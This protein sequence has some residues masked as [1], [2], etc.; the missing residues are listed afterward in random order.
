MNSGEFDGLKTGKAKKAVTYKLSQLERGEKKVTYKLRDWVFSRQ[1]YWGEPIPITFPYLIK[2]E[3]R[4]RRARWTLVLRM[5]A[6]RS[7]SASRKRCPWTNYL[8]NSRR[9][10]TTRPVR[11][12][13]AV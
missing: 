5:R 7:T 13:R 1:R 2:M 6:S 10:T 3:R 9:P 12:P 8:S 11:T 4:Y